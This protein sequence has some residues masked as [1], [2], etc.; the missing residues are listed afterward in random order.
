M[1]NPLDRTVHG[2]VFL[3]LSKA[4][5]SKKAPYLL[6]SI[7]KLGKQRLTVSL[8]GAEGRTKRWLCETAA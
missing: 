3:F 5:F 2:A 1:T 4:P 7:Q 8:P 6:Q